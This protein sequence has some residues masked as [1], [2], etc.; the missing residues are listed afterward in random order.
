MLN[1]FIS[2]IIWYRVN[3]PG[4][5]ARCSCPPTAYMHAFGG[6]K[7][8]RA[9]KMDYPMYVYTHTHTPSTVHRAQEQKKSQW[10]NGLWT[11]REAK[12]IFNMFMYS[13]RHANICTK[14]LSSILAV[15][16]VTHLSQQQQQQHIVS[17]GL[18]AFFRL[19][20]LVFIRS[21]LFVPSVHFSPLG[22]AFFSASYPVTHKYT[23]NRRGKKRCVLY[24]VIW[25]S[26]RRVSLPKMVKVHFDFGSLPTIF[27]I[28][29]QLMLQMFALCRANIF[30]I[31]VF[32]CSYSPKMWPIERE[33][34][35]MRKE[36][37]I[38]E[39]V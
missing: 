13:H 15:T 17:V 1:C 12:F 5:L 22:I 20:F 3:R 23:A 38:E 21:F 18:D 2:L 27:R 9:Q 36:R 10:L 26:V 35:K 8:R 29:I 7:K 34:E 37:R 33:R 28:S 25:P 39:W 4:S 24:W 31:L 30:C 11:S 16:P 6:L 32:F 14:S 19:D